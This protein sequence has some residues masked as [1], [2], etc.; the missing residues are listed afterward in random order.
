MY[1]DEIENCSVNLS[2][3]VYFLFFMFLLF[4]RIGISAATKKKLSIFFVCKVFLNYLLCPEC[5]QW[6]LVGTLP[7]LLVS[8]DAL[9]ETKRYRKV[10]SL[11]VVGF[12]WV[13][14]PFEVILFNLF[15]LHVKNKPRKFK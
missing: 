9:R 6:G 3:V 8:I 11:R 13:A 5:L 14:G 15:I 12:L 4:G 10:R 7:P 1:S 2:L